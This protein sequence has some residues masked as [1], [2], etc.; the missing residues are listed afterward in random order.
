LTPIATCNEFLDIFVAIVLIVAICY[1][2]VSAF[3]AFVPKLFVQFLKDL[4]FAI[5]YINN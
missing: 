1:F 5:V 3:P 2:A 4:C